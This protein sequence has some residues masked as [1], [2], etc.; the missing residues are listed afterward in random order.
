MSGLVNIYVT[1]L[2]TG[3]AAGLATGYATTLIT[4]LITLFVSGL[5]CSLTA[6][7]VITRV[8]ATLVAALITGFVTGSSFGFPTCYIGLLGAGFEFPGAWSPRGH[9]VG[10][11]EPVAR[12]AGELLSQGDSPIQNNRRARH[13]VCFLT[14]ARHWDSHLVWIT[15]TVTLIASRF[16]NASRLMARLLS[17]VCCAS[18]M[19]SEASA[20]LGLLIVR[21][22]HWASAASAKCFGSVAVRRAP[23]QRCKI[24]RSTSWKPTPGERL[25]AHAQQLAVARHSQSKAQRV[26]PCATRRQ[27][28]PR[29]IKL[30]LCPIARPMPFAISSYYT[31]LAQVTPGSG[32]ALR[33]SAAAPSLAL[34]RMLPATM[35]RRTGARRAG[36][37]HT[38]VIARPA[39]KNKACPT[40]TSSMKTSLEGSPGPEFQPAGPLAVSKSM[41]DGT[42]R[43]DAPCRPAPGQ[44]RASD[45]SVTLQPPDPLGGG[46]K[47]P[48]RA[49]AGRA[50]A[51]KSSVCQHGRCNFDRPC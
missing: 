39:C 14:S 44:P 40:Y 48:G 6:E 25:T 50:R 12:F 46:D 17:V 51:C 22:R 32:S 7:C 43:C 8:L 37:P 49:L 4:G 31:A 1:V 18:P 42:R 38:R 30:R 20:V 21:G 33:S 26:A 9:R 28:W 24:M 34:G 23:W 11:T 10:V 27:H 15:G 16:A 35:L 3:I 13:R 36:A 41:G 29:S 5:A 45:H 2:F 47:R 19:G